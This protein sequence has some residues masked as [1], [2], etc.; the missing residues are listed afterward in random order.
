MTFSNQSLVYFHRSLNTLQIHKVWKA[1]T[2]GN[3]L[4]QMCWKGVNLI[5]ISNCGLEISREGVRLRFSSR[6]TIVHIHLIPKVARLPA[7]WPPAA[8]EFIKTKIS[9]AMSN[10][11]NGHRWG[12]R[13]NVVPIP[14]LSFIFAKNNFSCLKFTKLICCAQVRFIILTRAP[15]VPVCTVDLYVIKLRALWSEQCA[16]CWDCSIL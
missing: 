8:P 16:H 14:N 6:W 1:F 11:Q 3:G 12:S 13:F 15:L 2:N 7:L 4:P 10:D 9:G 5:F